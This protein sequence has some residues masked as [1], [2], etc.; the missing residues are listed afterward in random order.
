[1][2]KYKAQIILQNFTDAIK[3]LQ[4][5]LRKIPT[6]IE[7]KKLVNNTEEIIRDGKLKETTTEQNV[8]LLDWL[9]TNGSDFSKLELR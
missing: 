1:M 7:L 2:R 8:K 4:T 9:K 3:T 6:S 5:G